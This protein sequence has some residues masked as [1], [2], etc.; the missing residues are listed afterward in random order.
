MLVDKEP[1][2]AARAVVSAGECNV[3]KIAGVC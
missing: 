2:L 1:Q 3:A